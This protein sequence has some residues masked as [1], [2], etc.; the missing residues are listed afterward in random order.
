M[1]Q[2]V[3]NIL[4]RS[5]YE[6]RE[7][8]PSGYRNGKRMRKIMCGSGEIEIE[9]PKIVGSKKEFRSRVLK[10]WQRKS[11]ELMEVLPMLYVEGLSTRDFK[12]ALKPLWN[13]SGLSRSSISKANN[14]LKQS[15]S[16]WRKRDLSSEDIVYIFLDGYYCGVRMGTKDKEALLIAHGIRRDG[17]RVLLAVHLGGVESAESWKGVI[18][19]LKERGLKDPQ[20]V[21][22]DGNKG[23]KRALKD[24]WPEVPHQRCIVHKTRNVLDRVPKKHRAEVKQSLHKIFHAACLEDAL[25]EVKEFERKYAK[26]F[27]T[28]TEVLA[29]GLEECLTYYLY[30]ES[31]WKR[32]RTSNVIE[33]AFRE[34]RRRTDVIGRFPNEISALSIVFGVLEQDRL[35]W[36]GVKINLDD[37][38]NIQNA[39]L[40][41]RTQ[42]LVIKWAYLSEVA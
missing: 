34:I 37:N 13:G 31:H 7:E 17:K 28:A 21:I 12:R 10:K 30:P 39:V 32:I 24:L 41:F 25:R 5:K 22:S 38:A 29:L 8:A 40:K 26:Q 11:D 18:N 19:D 9:K 20:L 27:P 36:R 42:P 1:L 15:F 35:L 23:L 2:E 4:E 6:R 16:E 33:R 3:T 14:S